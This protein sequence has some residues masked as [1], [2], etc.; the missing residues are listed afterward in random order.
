VAEPHRLRR[1]AIA[2]GIAVVLALGAAAFLLQSLRKR[3]DARQALARARVELHHARSRSSADARDLTAAQD[4]VQGLHAQLSDI[5]DD[6]STIGTLDDQDLDAVRAA[7][8]AGLAGDLGAYN[9][10]VDRRAASDPAHDEALERLRQHVN[11]VLPV[12][13]PLS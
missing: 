3:D 11:A 2:C 1:R 13:D 9:A 5:T 12:L 4:V 8:Q 7:A 6:A 10:A